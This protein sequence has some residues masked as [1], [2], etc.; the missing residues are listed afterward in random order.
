MHIYNQGILRFIAFIFLCM[1]LFI[2]TAQ[3]SNFSND[4]FCIDMEKFQSNGISDLGKMVDKYTRNDGMTVLCGN[5]IVEFKKFLKMPSGSLKEGWEERKTKQWN[6]IYC[7]DPF[8]QAIK[9][10]WTI[11]LN[12][13]TSDGIRTWIKASCPLP[14]YF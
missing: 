1:L 2:Q 12:L 9:N 5:K 6:V 4:T 7:E 14:R 13:T 8:L 10:G 3:A 11:A